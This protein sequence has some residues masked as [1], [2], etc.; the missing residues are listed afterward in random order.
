MSFQTMWMKPLSVLEIRNKAEKQI[1]CTCVLGFK[2]NILPLSTNPESIAFLLGQP[3]KT[4]PI[5][6]LSL[7]L[8][9]IASPARGTHHC[10]IR[11]WF[12]SDSENIC[13]DSYKSGW[14]FQRL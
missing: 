1:V 8:G 5:H 11:R 3:E 4:E 14:W 7:S 2:N 12:H 10:S 13:S 9:L 6:Y